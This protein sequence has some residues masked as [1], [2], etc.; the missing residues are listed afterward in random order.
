MAHGQ[1]D[2][3]ENE[4]LDPGRVIIGQLDQHLDTAYLLE[5]ARRGAWLSFDQI[6]NM[7]PGTDESKAA[8]LVELA[9][10]GYGA[11]LL[12]SEGLTRKSGLVAYGGRPG[13]IHLLERFTLTL[14]EAGAGADMVR[15]VLIDN[16]ARALTIVPRQT[17]NQPVPRV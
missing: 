4:G 1:L 2:L 8:M 7:P 12:V 13:W 11:Q 3:I 9:E 16:P 6:G 5:I 17:D 14:M 10:A 15:T